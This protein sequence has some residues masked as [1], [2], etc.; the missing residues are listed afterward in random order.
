MCL[1]ESVDR[2]VEAAQPLQVTTEEGEEEIRI[3][4]MEED[5]VLDVVGGDKNRPRRLMTHLSFMREDSPLLGQKKKF[6]KKK[7]HSCL[8]IAWS[9]YE[10]SIE[11][12]PLLTKSVT[13]GI[14]TFLGEAISQLVSCSTTTITAAAAAATTTTTISA[15]T[16]HCRF[17]LHQS[18]DFFVLGCFFQAPVTHWFYLFLDDRLPPTAHPWTLTT[19]TKLLIDQLLF[20]PA[21]L[22]GFI[23]LLDLLDG[24]TAWETMHHLMGDYWPTLL[25]NWKLWVPATLIN[26]AFVAPP[27]RVLYNNLVFF[28]WSIILGVLLFHAGSNNNDEHHYAG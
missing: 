20:A 2:D 23:V 3:L 21:F 1:G 24:R 6:T 15:I 16:T 19:I 9:N 13:A 18:L 5:D 25:T 28:V 22:L 7:I 8:S 17:D 4:R 12:N 10:R 26:H 27:Y 14:L 11:R